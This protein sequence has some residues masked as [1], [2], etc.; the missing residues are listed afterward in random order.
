MLQSKIIKLGKNRIKKV[1]WGV[2]GLGK[3][4]ETAFLPAIAMLGRAKVNSLFSNDLRRAKSLAEKF[5][6]PNYFSNYD[7]FLASDIDAVYIGSINSDH[8]SQVMK[9][10]EAKK[11]ILCEKP[12]AMTSMQAEEMV[13]A[14]KENNVL[15]AVDYVYRFHPLIRKAKELVQ[16]KSIGSLIMMKA[17]FNINLV[18]AGNFR[19][20][21]EKS[22]GGASRDLATHLID[23]FRFIGGE[24]ISIKGIID[25]LIYK[26]EVDDF[27]TGLAQFENGGY[28]A[29]TVSYCSPKAVNRIEIIG[30][31]GSIV[32]DNLI[33]QRFASA[34][35]TLMFEGE[36]K[37]AFR[38]RANKIFRLLKSVNKSFLKNEAPEV[39]GV[40]G[41]INMKLLENFEQ[42]AFKK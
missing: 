8:Y 12:M 14:C 4:S 38:K 28:G 5:S 7:E 19:Y 30:H 33:S 36:T 16:S 35:M 41:M 20:Q 15:L 1:K 26:T 3:F 22:G 11:N 10:A 17:D 42:N 21:V 39:T 9:A 37:K 2:A 6:A 31:K 32:I 29:F 18:P 25:K 27:A 23:L 40:D 24:I 34:K 13:R